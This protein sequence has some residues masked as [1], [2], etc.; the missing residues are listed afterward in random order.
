MTPSDL[1]AQARR[2]ARA[3]RRR[4]RDVDLRR[5][6]S[7]AYYALF[8]AI[9]KAGADLLVGSV[10]AARSERAWKQVYRSLQHGDA[11]ARCES[12]PKAFSQDLVDVADAFISLQK[13]RHSADYDISSAFTRGDT[14]N[15]VLM[16][17]NAIAKLSRASTSD[18]R[19]FVVWLL[20]P[21]PR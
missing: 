12:L 9:A 10:G 8:H 16:A 18:R 1:L 4:P 11:K 17:E 6:V 19:A 20:F 7:A 3:T 2:L 13:L 14:L 15:H 21:K 5:A